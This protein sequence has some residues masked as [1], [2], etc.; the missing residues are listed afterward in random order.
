MNNSCSSL[1]KEN[2][3]LS[4][5]ILL[6]SAKL[7]FRMTQKLSMLYNFLNI[8]VSPGRIEININ[9]ITLHLLHFREENFLVME[10]ILNANHMYRIIALPF[11]K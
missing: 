9:T 10:R 1:E 8:G 4:S 5:C 7:C 3:F 6:S 11:L 2:C